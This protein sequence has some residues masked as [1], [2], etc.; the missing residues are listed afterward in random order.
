MLK[1]PPINCLIISVP[2]NAPTGRLLSF[3]LHEVWVRFTHRVDSEVIVQG[4]A[5]NSGTENFDKAPA[6]I[7]PAAAEMND[8]GETTVPTEVFM[9][10]WPQTALWYRD[11]RRCPTEESKLPAGSFTWVSI[12]L[13]RSTATGRLL[14]RWSSTSLSG[15]PKASARRHFGSQFILAWQVGAL[16]TCLTVVK[17][18]GE[19]W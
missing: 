10:A 13:A 7:T 1:A 9:A 16:Q 14:A 3:Y 17:E 2:A 15:I 11:W 6:S 5:D 12:R 8:K 18:D 19:K 4:K